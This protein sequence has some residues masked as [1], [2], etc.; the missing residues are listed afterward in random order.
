MVP[1]CILNDKDGFVLKLND[2]GKIVSAVMDCTDV[3][4]QW[5]TYG[6]LHHDNEDEDIFAIVP[7]RGQKTLQWDESGLMVKPCDYDSEAQQ[8]TMNKESFIVPRRNKC[9]NSLKLKVC[10]AVCWFVLVGALFY[11]LIVSLKYS[12]GVKRGI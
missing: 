10:P 9:W 8:W 1:M 12:E 4:Q 5:Y 7:R 3:N 2:D 6:L 11:T